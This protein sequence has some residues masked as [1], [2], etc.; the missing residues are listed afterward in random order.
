MKDILISERNNENNNTTIPLEQFGV[1]R[2]HCCSKH[3]CKYG[4]KDCPVVLGII[5][6]DYPCMDCNDSYDDLYFGHSDIYDL[7]I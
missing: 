5:K 1:H 7:D 2:K 3:G 4:D 6:Q